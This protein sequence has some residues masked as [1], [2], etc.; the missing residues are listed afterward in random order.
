MS[1]ETTLLSTL[2]IALIVRFKKPFDGILLGVKASHKISPLEEILIPV[3]CFCVVESK[4]THL[5]F[6]VIFY[7]YF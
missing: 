3:I 4:T 5:K 1:L 7:S 2:L 6:W